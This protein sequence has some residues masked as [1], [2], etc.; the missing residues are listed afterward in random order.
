M[1]MLQNHDLG[2]DEEDF[3]LKLKMYCPDIYDVKY[4]MG[5]CKELRGG[6]QEIADK[7]GVCACVY[8]RSGVFMLSITPN[9]KYVCFL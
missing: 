5:S 1:R 8:L 9:N 4:L 6:L 3:F 7:L 2:A